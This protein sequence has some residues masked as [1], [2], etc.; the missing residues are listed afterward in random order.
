MSRLAV[1]EERKPGHERLASP[2]PGRAMSDLTHMIERRRRLM[3]T[4]REM[5]A[6][7]LDRRY[8]ERAAHSA[9][10]LNHSIIR[11]LRDSPKSAGACARQRA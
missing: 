4:A 9:R 5:R 6:A 2:Y 11:A 8:Q 10:R 1:T 7:R 3:R